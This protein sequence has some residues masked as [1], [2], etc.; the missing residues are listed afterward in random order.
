VDPDPS[1]PYLAG[2]EVL[3]RADPVGGDAEQL[4]GL[5]GG[6]PVTVTGHGLHRAM[7]SAS[8]SGWMRRSWPL[9]GLGPTRI[10]GN[11]P[12]LTRL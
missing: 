10:A 4:R 3:A 11:S 8:S 1:V 7:Y 5:R 2:Q 12:R 6:E 9:P